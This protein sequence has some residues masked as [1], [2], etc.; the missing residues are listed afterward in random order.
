MSPWTPA[1]IVSYIF[2]GRTLKKIHNGVKEVVISHVS[3]NSPQLIYQAAKIHYIFI[4]QGFNGFKVVHN[5]M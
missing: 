1:F 5:F 2:I 4:I 3:C